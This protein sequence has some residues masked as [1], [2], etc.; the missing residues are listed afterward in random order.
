MNIHT[1]EA[2]LAAVLV[3]VSATAGCGQAEYEQRLERSVAAMQQ[4][5]YTPGMMQQ[6]AAQ[7][8][9]GQAEALYAAGQ[10]PG[11]PLTIRVPS[12]FGNTSNSQPPFAN[13]PGLR[14]TYEATTQDSAGGQQPSY[15]YVAALP[16]AEAQQQQA[17]QT[18]QAN[19][20]RALPDCT[21][22]ASAGLSKPWQKIQASGQ[23]EFAYVNPSGQSAPAQMPGTIE[24]YSLEEGGHLVLV[25]WRAPSTLIDALAIRTVLPQSLESVAA[26]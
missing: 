24:F 5:N 12:V 15:F 10:I 19:I 1:E 4:G 11:V 26:Q 16:L 21:D 14:V 22:W 2:I 8:A 9:A 7:Q 17:V 6:T 18:L 3:A 13:V 25:G 23:Q 20:K